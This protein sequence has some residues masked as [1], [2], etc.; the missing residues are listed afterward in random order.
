MSDW[1]DI[2]NDMLD[3]GYQFYGG[4][5][6]CDLDLVDEWAEGGYTALAFSFPEDF[7]QEEMNKMLEEWRKKL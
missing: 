1:E 2:R 3:K 4:T 5:T 6:G 7:D